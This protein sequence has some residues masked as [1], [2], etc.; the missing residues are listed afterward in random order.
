MSNS[1]SRPHESADTSGPDRPNQPAG[2]RGKSDGARPAKRTSAAIADEALAREALEGI[3]R[4]RAR[5]RM[6]KIALHKPDPAPVR[7]AVIVARPPE[8]RPTWLMPIV[9]LAVAVSMVV[10]ACTG[11]IAYL[12]MQPTAA[13]PVA[14]A[15][16]QSLRETVAQLRRQVAGISEHLDGLRSAVDLSSR[17][18]SDRF[19]RFAENLDRIERANSSA[20]ARIEKIAEVQAQAASQ[21]MPRLASIPPT[22]EVTGSVAPPDKAK[23]PRRVVKGWSVRQGYEGIA[24]LQGPPGVVEV[25]LG[26]EVPGLGRIEEMKIENGRWVVLSSAGAI[27]SAQ[28]QEE[29]ATM[30]QENNRGR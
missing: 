20:T 27:V 10:C 14:S 23:A 30:P 22:V 19:G 24:I 1:E 3:K 15:E 28:K 5:A 21:S 4:V 13:K 2:E 17:A 12:T 11:V 25:L 29:V 7:P 26:Q 16:I 8:P 18:N 6:E 9:A